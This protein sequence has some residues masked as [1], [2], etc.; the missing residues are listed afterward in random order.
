MALTKKDLKRLGKRGGQIKPPSKRG[1]D[2]GPGVNK[3]PPLK[4]GAA[5][6]LKGFAKK[7]RKKAKKG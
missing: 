2:N 5:A 3:L 7:K 1:S 4:A 6:K